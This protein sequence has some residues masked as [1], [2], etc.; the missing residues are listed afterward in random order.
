[1]SLSDSL[2]TKLPHS[3]DCSDESATKQPRHEELQHSED[4]SDDSGKKRPR[5]EELPHSEDCSDEVPEP[6]L[7]KLKTPMG[8]IF[9]SLEF[10]KI[11]QN[12]FFPDDKLKS[13]AQHIIDSACD[14]KDSQ[15]MNL[16]TW[17]YGG[18]MDL[19]DERRNFVQIFVKLMTAYM[20][21]VLINEKEKVWCV[22][23]G[24]TILVSLTDS[25]MEGDIP[26]FFAGPLRL[27]LLHNESENLMEY[28]A[29]LRKDMRLAI[30]DDGTVLFVFVDNITDTPENLGE[31][32]Y[33]M[34]FKIMGTDG[35]WYVVKTFK[36]KRTAEEEWS[37]LLKVAGKNKCLQHGVR[38]MTDQSGY[39]Q[40]F[41]VSKYQ[42]EMVLSDL[43]K[44]KRK[45]IPLQN[46]LFS[47]LEMS[48]GICVV[49]QHGFIHG[50]IK[51]ANIVF[52]PDFL[53]LV[54]IDFGIATPF[55]KNPVR[56]DSLY[57]WWFRFPRLFLEKLMIQ[58][59]NKN[60]A[61][62]IHPTELFSGM[63]W[64]AFFVSILHTFS[65]P[66]C[67][68]LGFRSMD[69]DEARKEMFRISPVIRL[70]KKLK[71]WLTEEL[72]MNFVL[73]VYWVLF[74]SGGSAEFIRVFSEFGVDLPSGE[75]MYDEYHRLFNKWRDE[76]PMKTRVRDIFNHIKCEDKNIDITAHIQELSD[77][78]VE[79]ICDGGDFSIVGVFTTHIRGW[80]IRLN[81]I[82]TKM[83]ALNKRI[84]FY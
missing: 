6:L 22:S 52:S 75:A 5:Q 59:F 27:E 29:T 55:G 30:A 69:E 10:L 14:G 39:F 20:Q 41:I 31:G 62:I 21:Y 38:L 57:T 11:L 63:D 26:V 9:S 33:G 67:D 78:F 56:P 13:C 70:M 71:H 51:P 23:N 72:G 48:K 40:H 34:A 61:T 8:S 54:L 1:M 35:K 81:E 19:L 32:S 53:S 37:F 74:K 24:E 77:L 42:G 12:M 80:L 76:N 68:F 25:A 79:I 2:T 28:Y 36:D 84:F 60:F 47:F 50:D 82:L 15:L 58:E 66:S 83:N 7:K 46:M 73:N 43:K 18:K 44:N 4:C 64:W 45:R 17:V 3:E 65:Q 49:H 16:Y